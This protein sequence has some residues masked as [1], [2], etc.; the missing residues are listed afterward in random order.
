MIYN[1][2][3]LATFMGFPGGASGKEPACQCRR[4]NRYRFNP[5]VGMIPW[6]R[7]HGN[8]LYYS[9]LENPMDREAW[10]ATVHSV[11]KSRIRVKQLMHTHMYSKCLSRNSGNNWQTKPNK[12]QKL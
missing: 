5:W 7:G 4:L 6:R 3:W 10:R 8:P 2:H 1:E 9:C 12:I 11:A